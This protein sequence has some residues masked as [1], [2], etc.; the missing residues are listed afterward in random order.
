MESDTADQDKSREIWSACEKPFHELRG[1]SNAIPTAFSFVKK[2]E[3]LTSEQS[4]KE[5]KGC[6][7]ASERFSSKSTQEHQPPSP[8]CPADQSQLHAWRYPS[9]TEPT[10][11]FF[12]FHQGKK[13]ENL[14]FL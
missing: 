5:S 9:M 7:T 2:N 10:L 14:E 13:T 1:H 4:V 6:K 3:V 12:P 11:D 8:S